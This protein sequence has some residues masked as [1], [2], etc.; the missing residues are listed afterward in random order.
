LCRS[1]PA[2][3]FDEFFF[4]NVDAERPNGAGAFRRFDHFLAEQQCTC[5]RCGGKNVSARLGCSGHDILLRFTIRATEC[6][7]LTAARKVNILAR[8]NDA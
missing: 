5:S 1:D 8:A 2:A 6:V 7:T 4:W 3:E